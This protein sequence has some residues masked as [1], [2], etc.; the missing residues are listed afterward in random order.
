MAKGA[1]VGGEDEDIPVPTP[2]PTPKAALRGSAAKRMQGNLAKDAK[3]APAS[4]GR[5]ANSPPQN[6]R[7][8]LA[9]LFGNRMKSRRAK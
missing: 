9:E 1:P 2:V 6:L 3:T 8:P 5:T 4:G 7:N